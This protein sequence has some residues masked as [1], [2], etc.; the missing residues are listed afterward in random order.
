MASPV[1][2]SDWLDLGP[3]AWAAYASCK[4]HTELHFVPGR[5]DPIEPLK[6]IC[7]RCLVHQECL[8]YALAD[9]TL[10]GVWGGT[11]ERERR[12]ITGL[13]RGLLANGWLTTLANLGPSRPFEVPG[14]RSRPGTRTASESGSAS[15]EAS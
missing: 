14:S 8:A 7:R 2:G 11:T 4:E 1:A 15:P 9:Q 10:V 5:G 6:A 12:V 3:P 13:S